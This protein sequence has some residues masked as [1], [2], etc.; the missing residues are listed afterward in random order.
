M[1]PGFL[2]K[3]A[4]A[5]EQRRIFAGRHLPGPLIR[6]DL[7]PFLPGLD[8]LR[9]HALHTDDA[10]DAYRLALHHDVN[11]AFNPAADPP[12][13]T[14]NPRQAPGHTHRARPPGRRTHC[15]VRRLEAPRRTGLPHL[16][17]AVL[18]LPLMNTA[19]ARDELG[20]TPR[21]SSTD[22]LSQFCAA[23]ATEPEKTP[24]RSRGTK[25]NEPCGA[26]DQGTEGVA[27]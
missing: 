25:R 13:D 1:R 24:R 19:R 20:W 9:F 16:F 27:R 10:A 14:G 15:A 26:G 6:P 18:R 5:S 17:D 3:E 23:Y 12:L 11:G 7:L 2:F 8:G 22:A 21:R 4:A